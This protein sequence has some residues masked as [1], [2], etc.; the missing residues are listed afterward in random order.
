M[1]IV[2]AVGA[3][4][5]SSIYPYLFY[6]ILIIIVVVI[7]LFSFFIK[8]K[9]L[10]IL[11]TKILQSRI[12][13][14]IKDRVENSI[15]SFYED[16]PKFKDI[17]LPLNISIFGWIIKYIMLFFI[18]KLFFIEIPFLSF[19][20]IMAV[21]DVIASLPISIYGLGTREAALVTIFNIWGVESENI[22]SLS[23]FLFVIIWITPSII[24]AFVTFMETK[25]L[26]KFVLTDKTIRK[27][28]S[29]MRKYPK[30]YQYTTEI[31]KKNILKK[32]DKPV[33]IDLGSGPGL[34]SLEMG[35]QIN[36]AR[37][38][39]I[40]PSDKMLELANKN[41]RTEGFQTINGT[42][43][44]I[45]LKNDFADIVVSRFSLTY[46]E[47]PMESF[48]EIHRVL[49][50]GGKFILEALNKDFPKY[51]LFLIKIHMFFKFAGLDVIRYHIDS[52]KT[53]YKIQHVE[54]L[55][56]K[57]GY[58]ITYKEFNKNEWKYL[59]VAKKD[60]KK[61]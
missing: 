46:W 45:D 20:M 10:K 30:L 18:A 15:E 26:E 27:F 11:F 17:L 39:A 28:E 37:I 13:A 49:K 8:G 60:N 19:I 1:L 41:V 29:Y 4:Y 38:I 23:L 53:A 31:V 50:P 51:Y 54:M 32:A 7:F 57:T 44:H 12:F 24:G 47:K 22:I 21:A 35:K 5:I 34:L 25:K 36:G 48:I 43:D 6:Q 55:L 33:I 56:K 3:I 14:T 16:L 58:K 52:Y 40:D 9:R 42:S 2:G 61:I 59:V